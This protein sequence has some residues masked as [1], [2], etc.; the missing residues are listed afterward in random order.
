MEQDLNYRKVLTDE[1]EFSVERDFPRVTL[2]AIKQTRSLLIDH[3]AFV[4]HDLSAK[5]A[6]QELYKN[7]CAVSSS[8][9][10]WA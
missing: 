9:S 4:L 6:R 7:Y 2:R 5:L 10:S 3:T 1:L 8:L